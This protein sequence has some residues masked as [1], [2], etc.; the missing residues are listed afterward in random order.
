MKIITS[1]EDS[2]TVYLEFPDIRVIFRD[3]VY[4]GWYHPAGVESEGA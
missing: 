3:G 2:S 4:V 1:C